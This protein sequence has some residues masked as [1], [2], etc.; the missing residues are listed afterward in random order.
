MEALIWILIAG[1]VIGVGIWAQARW[2][3]RKRKGKDQ[4]DE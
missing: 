1:I 2:L 3:T 4:L